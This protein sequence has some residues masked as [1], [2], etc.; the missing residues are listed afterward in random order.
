MMNRSRGSRSSRWRFTLCLSGLLS[1]QLALGAVAAPD[2]APAEPTGPEAVELVE[3]LRV[4]S[5]LNTLAPTREQLT[6]LTAVAVSGQE[7]LRDL[8]AAVSA[9]LEAQRDRILAAREKARHGGSVSQSTDAQLAVAIQLAE[10]TRAQKLEALIG[11][12]TVRV[13]RILTPEQAAR[14][15][16]E[17][18]PTLDH[19]WR[20]YQG[21]LTRTGAA[22]GNSRRMPSDPGKWLGELRD[23]RID[24]AEGDPKHEVEDFGKKLTRG[25]QP[26]TPLYAQ[27]D[28]QARA[29]AT[30][31]LAMPPSV[32][33]QQERELARRVAK[34]ELATRNQ[35]NV[36]DGKPVE[37]FD[38]YRWFVE[39]V[40]LSP[41]APIDFRDRAG[42]R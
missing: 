1:A 12:L 16:S 37:L 20:R 4:L 8:E 30:Q 28:A 14:I 5:M 22:T 18:A 26:G 34:Q 11:T 40:V 13:R 10:T 35:Q 41:R 32:F 39:E 31:V 2:P 23:L 29:F 21:V 15:E 25:L 33:Q 7:G 24:S 19:P 3:D 38:P 6:R 36:L 9:K 17:L 42:V 27:S